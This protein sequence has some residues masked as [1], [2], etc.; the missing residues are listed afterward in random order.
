MDSNKEKMLVLRK[1][2]L[3]KTIKNKILLNR[4]RAVMFKNFIFLA[5]IPGILKILIQMKL[6]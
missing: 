4:T 1:N 3:V 5:G 2:H 6:Q